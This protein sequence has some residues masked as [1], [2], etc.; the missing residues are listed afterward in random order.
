MEDL[1]STQGRLQ[2]CFPSNIADYIVLNPLTPGEKFPSASGNHRCV[3]CSSM[4]ETMWLFDLVS[5]R[6][7]MQRRCWESGF[8]VFILASAGGKSRS[9]SKLWGRFPITIVLYLSGP[10]MYWRRSLALVSFQ[11]AIE[12]WSGHAKCYSWARRNWKHKTLILLQ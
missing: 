4:I 12:M 8:L 7:L 10:G 9:I 6:T 3:S 5:E 2:F 11:Q 1:H